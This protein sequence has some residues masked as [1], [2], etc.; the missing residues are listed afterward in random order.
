MATYDN[1]NQPERPQTPQQM[2]SQAS[3]T[4]PQSG[5]G[6]PVFDQIGDFVQQA[7]GRKATMQDVSQW[8]TNVDANYMGHI[9]NAIYNSAEAKAYGARQAQGQQQQTQQQTDGGQQSPPPATGS[10][11]SGDGKIPAP[12]NA[13][14]VQQAQSAVQNYTAP[15]A[16]PAPPA[17]RNLAPMTLDQTRLPTYDPA[18]IS[19]FNAPNQGAQNGQQNALLSAILTNPQTMNPSV[20]AQMK[21]QQKQDALLMQHQNQ[22]QLDQGFTARGTLGGGAAQAAYGANNNDTINRIL[23]GNRDLD[24]KAATQN[25]QDELNALTASDSTLA[26]QMAR[27]SQGYTTGLAGQQAQADQGYKGFE[28]QVA[29]QQDAVQRALAQFGINQSVASNA[30]QNYGQ[31]LGSF[32]NLEDLKR[33]ATQTNNSSMMAYLNY[34]ENQR[35]FNGQLGYN[36]NQL[37]QNGQTT[38]LNYLNQ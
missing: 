33:G 21:E 34:L 19:Q 8:G 26:G 18:H 5:F 6:H 23:S 35:Q 20:L 3:P 30:Q 24:I 15:T 1:P 4:Q 28:S 37:D 16:A 27:A 14:A 11:V 36:Y 17:A 2:N 25:R 29:S 7:T 12:N 32:F 10:P 31:D 13:G 22:Q 9:R 38:L